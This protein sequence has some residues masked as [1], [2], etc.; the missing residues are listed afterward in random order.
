MAVRRVCTGRYDRGGAYMSRY[1]NFDNIVEYLRAIRM[2]SKINDSPYMDAALL[3]MQQ[4]LE[5]DIC[6][7]LIFDCIEIGGCNDCL[8]KNRYQKC[9][10][11]RRN[12]KL[13]DCYKE[14]EGE[15]AR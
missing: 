9:S 8:W 13:K 3:N 5:L 7:I 14:K 6:N 4:L 15:S 12:R 1:V 11:C 2:N 10:C